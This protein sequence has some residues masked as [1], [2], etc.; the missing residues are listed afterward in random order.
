MGKQRSNVIPSPV[1]KMAF[2]SAET[3]LRFHP[4]DP[5]RLHQIHLPLAP[6]SFELIP[7]SI[8]RREVCSKVVVTR[9]WPKTGPR[10]REER[11]LRGIPLLIPN[12]NPVHVWAG[13]CGYGHGGGRG[14]SLPF[15]AV[16]VL[17]VNVAFG[18]A[19]E[20]STG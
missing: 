3:A 16:L 9:I 11:L 14:E 5:V 2:K 8:D 20:D 6:F 7:P 12:P 1:S 10:H 19:L 15:I 13:F 17:T 4:N 18:E